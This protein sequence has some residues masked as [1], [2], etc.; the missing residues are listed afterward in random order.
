MVRA[1]FCPVSRISGNTTSASHSG[2]AFPTI[3][4][5]SFVIGIRRRFLSLY[6]LSI[7]SGLIAAYVL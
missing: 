6:N 7:N 5:T 4:L 1:P 3:R 2:K